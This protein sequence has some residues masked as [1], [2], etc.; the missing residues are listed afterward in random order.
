MKCS[1]PSD[2]DSLD[3]LEV[4]E[5]DEEDESDRLLRDLMPPD[6]FFFEALFANRTRIVRNGR[7]GTVNENLVEQSTVVV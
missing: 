2:S 7:N 4:E 5:E 1:S 3:S 6:S